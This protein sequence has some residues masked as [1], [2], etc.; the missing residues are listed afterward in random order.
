[1]HA[2]QCAYNVLGHFIVHFKL[3]V[4][5]LHVHVRCILSAEMCNVTPTKCQTSYAI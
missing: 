3:S 4:G 1:M 2:L 5:T